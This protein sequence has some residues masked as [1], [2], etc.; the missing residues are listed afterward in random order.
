MMH[1][2]KTTNE[3]P[4]PTMLQA[5]IIPGHISHQ[6]IH[7]ILGVPLEGSTT[8]TRKSVLFLTYILSIWHYKL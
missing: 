1:F 7:T 6:K 3:P 4:L 5:M 8:L 2:T